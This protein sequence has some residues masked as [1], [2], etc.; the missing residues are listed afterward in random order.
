M[1]E[2]ARAVRR[3]FGDVDAPR[4]LAARPHG[5]RRL[6]VQGVL[7]DDVAAYGAGLAR[8][9]AASMLERIERPSRGTP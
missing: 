3:L 6:M 1:V 2:Q 9:A 8:Y 4:A 7:R 5:M